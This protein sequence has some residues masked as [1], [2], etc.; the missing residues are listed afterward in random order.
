MPV[1]CRSCD[2]DLIGLPGRARCPECG[3][4]R[5]YIDRPVDWR[6]FRRWPGVLAPVGV[7]ASVGGIGLLA[8]GVVGSAA[9]WVLV[10]EGLLVLGLG[11]VS[12]E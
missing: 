9:G 1:R 3:G 8:A 7:G 12:W 5:R 10:I 4:R 11:L 6:R 2:Y